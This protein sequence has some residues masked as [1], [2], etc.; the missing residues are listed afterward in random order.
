MKMAVG[1]SLERTI[2]VVAATLASFIGFLVIDFTGA[3]S[4]LS[5]AKI[6]ATIELMVTLKFV[7]YFMGISIG[8]YFELKII[9]G[10]ICTIFNI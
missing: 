6:L 1:K 7:V 4:G 9:F 5:A 10:R 3:G 8:L 2:G